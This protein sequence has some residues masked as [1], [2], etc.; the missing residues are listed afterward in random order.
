M[1][2][3]KIT[4]AE[5]GVRITPNDGN[6]WLSVWEIAKTFDVFPAKVNANIKS[7]LKSNVLWKSDV[8]RCEHYANG[9]SVDLYNARNDNG[10][11]FSYQ[12]EEQRNFQ[13]LVN[14]TRLF[15]NCSHNEIFI[16]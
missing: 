6:V 3:G 12:I 5:N 14:K 1:E 9:S 15:T 7:I 13:K 10:I 8:C 2:R 11:G 4:I 16:Q